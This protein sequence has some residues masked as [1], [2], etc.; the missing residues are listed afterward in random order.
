MIISLLDLSRVETR[1]G[2]FALVD[3][4][5]AL[6]HSRSILAWASVW[7]SASASWSGAAGASGW[8]RR[9]AWAR[10]SIS[11]FPRGH[12]ASLSVCRVS[13]LLVSRK[14][15]VKAGFRDGYRCRPIYKV[16]LARHS[17]PMG[18]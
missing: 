8:I 11:R 7:C 3:V 2:E 5:A 12:N 9:W 4:K 15:M 17:R 10:R 18:L 14:F 13:A 1:G 16:V 6:E